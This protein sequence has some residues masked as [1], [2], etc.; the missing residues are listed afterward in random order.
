MES[1]LGQTAGNLEYYILDNGSADGTGDIIREFAARD[2]RVHPLA[3][4]TNT[5]MR[6]FDPEFLGFKD[7]EYDYWV[8]LD[9]DDQYKPDFLEKA[10][11]FIEETG[12]GIA[13]VGSDFI[14]GPTGRELG[15]RQNPA[16]G[17][18]DARALERFFPESYQFLRTIWGKLYR[19]SVIESLDWDRYYGFNLGNGRDTLF[20]FHA[21]ERVEKL[22]I[23]SGTLHRYYLWPNSIY[24]TW[25]NARAKA[26]S[27]LFAEGERLLKLKAGAVSPRNLDFLL[28]VY[29]SSV[30]D[31]M[32]PLFTSEIPQEEKIAAALEIFS[33]PEMRLLAKT[34]VSQEAQK[35]VL[36]D[37]ACSFLKLDL[38]RNSEFAREAAELCAALQG[39]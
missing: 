32:N 17:V 28:L 18:L 23:L 2:A 38:V 4:E 10:I 20:V 9:A 26:Y 35:R 31:M 13:C 1:V 33:S 29:M 11:A 15:K 25:N 3:E 16:P 22:A 24:K 12:A 14:D 30:V 37:A 39:G 36:L 8:M 21:L 5:P 6:R 19:K 34:K 27:V 7:L